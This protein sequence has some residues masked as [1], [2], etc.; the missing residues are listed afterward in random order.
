MSDIEFLFGRLE[1]GFDIGQG[2]ALSGRRQGQGLP[3]R[4]TAEIPDTCR[5]GSN[6]RLEIIDQ[7]QIGIGLQRLG[8]RHQIVDLSDILV[9]QPVTALNPGQF[10]TEQIN[11]APVKAPQI[12][13]AELDTALREAI[14]R[15]PCIPPED[16]V[17][18]ADRIV[19]DLGLRESG[20]TVRQTSETTTDR[21]CASFSVDQER[22]LIAIVPIP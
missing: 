10:T 16:A 8:G 9:R 2:Q 13:I 15:T 14:N 4:F 17:P 20:W 5:Q 18:A 11:P 19:T 1:T 6:Q 7:G 3:D 22:K 21:P 12:P